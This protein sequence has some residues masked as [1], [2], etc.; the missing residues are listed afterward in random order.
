MT[1]SCNES[2]VLGGY[3][4]PFQLTICFNFLNFARCP[5]SGKGRLA[6]DALRQ[7]RGRV[8]EDYYV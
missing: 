4:F 7:R 6:A 5:Q 1:Q 3:F 8:K 2:V